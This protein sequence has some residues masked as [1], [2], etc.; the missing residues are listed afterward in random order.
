MV[1]THDGATDL[2]RIGLV[3][4]GVGHRDRQ[5]T[6]D[7]RVDQI[8]EIDEADDPPSPDQHVV[9][10][11]VAV[12]DA[13]T[14]CTPVNPGPDVHRT[15]NHLLLLGAEQLQVLEGQVRA[16][17]VPVQIPVH[18]RVG[19]PSQR[20]IELRHGR[21]QRGQQRFIV[22]LGVDQHFAIQPANE[23]NEMCPSRRHL[24]AHQVISLEC[25]PDPGHRQVRSASGH[26]PEG[27]VLQ[28][29]HRPILVGLGDLEHKASS[30]SG[31]QQEV[32][33]ALAGQRQQ[34]WP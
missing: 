4:Q 27:G 23:A 13:V 12:D 7:G 3:E 29:K 10:V 18:G 6:G 31:V 28:L 33:I 11:G 16:P 15:L 2:G 22:R 30:R 34:P 21:A 5:I 20:L 25:R 8:T 14:Q 17:D 32:L 24:N 1:S 26:L 19:K 9:I